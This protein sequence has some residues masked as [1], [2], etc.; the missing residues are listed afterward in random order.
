[1]LKTSRYFRILWH[2]EC[3]W[4][5]WLIV[6]ET[7][8]VFLINLNWAPYQ[9]MWR[10]LTGVC[11]LTFIGFHCKEGPAYPSHLISVSTSMQTWSTLPQQLLAGVL[12]W[13]PRGL[14]FAC[15]II[16]GP[17]ASSKHHHPWWQ[18]WKGS[19]SEHPLNK[20]FDQWWQLSEE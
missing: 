7:F 15:K 5:R 4:P 12:E 6:L 1:M 16:A 2:I 8:K 20:T 9:F 19:T 18:D 13:H 3:N 17:K 10:A 11:L 14:K